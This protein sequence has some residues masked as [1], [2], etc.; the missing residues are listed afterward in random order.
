MYAFNHPSRTL[1]H[2]VT[3]ERNQQFKLLIRTKI[4]EYLERAEHLKK[5]ISQPRD[6]API[7][8]KG[9]QY[10]CLPTIQRLGS[11][12]IS[13]VADADPEIQRLQATLSESIL[14]E[15][16]N[17][18]WDDIAG[19]EGAKLAMKEA[20]IVPIRFPQL[21]TGGGR[22][23]WR[24]ILL[25]GPP[26]TGKSYLA[27]AVATE[28]KGTFFSVSSSDIV[29][30]WQGESEKC[31]KVVLFDWDLILFFR[32]IGQEPLPNGAKVGTSCH[33]HRRNRLSRHQSW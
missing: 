9:S 11:N 3:D 2:W 17:I 7:T 21:F 10:A 5:L 13:R 20:V 30:K 33:L 22:R 18:G 24:G 27:K 26:G 12:P 15:T 28:A 25:Y 23:A 31:V 29:S 32:K 1:S 16:P 8:A 19:L 4:T 6:S 14:S